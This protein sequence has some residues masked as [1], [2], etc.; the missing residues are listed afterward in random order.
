MRYQLTTLSLAVFFLA[1][2]AKEDA[3]TAEYEPIVERASYPSK[4]SGV[5]RA[6]DSENTLLRA[7]GKPDDK[8]AID[9]NTVKW[10][11]GFSYV[12]VHRG[13]VKSW[14][15]SGNDLRCAGG[16]GVINEEEKVVTKNGVTSSVP[17]GVW[18][19]KSASGNNKYV[20]P[21]KVIVPAHTRQ[22]GTYVQPYIRTKANST[23]YDNLRGR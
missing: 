9:N 20:N 2:C 21:E 22:D 14:L 11:Y 1:S 3:P 7:M 10:Y 23:T 19:G 18:S 6:G 4:P 12:I 17:H 16:G 5:F 15:N 8:R 13:R